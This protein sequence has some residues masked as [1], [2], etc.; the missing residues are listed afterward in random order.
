MTNISNKIK[1]NIFE[2]NENIIK[3]TMTNFSNKIITTFSGKITR[4]IMTN[5]FGQNNET[6]FRTKLHAPNLWVAVIVR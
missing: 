3:Q 1:I 2:Q 5:F 6:K 4:Q